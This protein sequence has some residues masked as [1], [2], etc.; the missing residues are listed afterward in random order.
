VQYV[1]TGIVAEEANIKLAPNY[2]F[3]REFFHIHSFLGIIYQDSSSGCVCQKMIKHLG[4]QYS[5]MQNVVDKKIP[6]QNDDGNT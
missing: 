3:S 1:P 4:T 5:N 2:T 6:N